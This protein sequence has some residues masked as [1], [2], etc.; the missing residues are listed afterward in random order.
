MLIAATNSWAVSFDNLSTIQPWLSDSLCRL[1]TGGGLSVREL[2]SDD[3]ER[4]FDCVRP[5][6]IAAIENVAV[7]GDL[8]DRCLVVAL[9][10]I[11]KGKRQDER[12]FW[13]AFEEARPAILGALLDAIAVG[14]GRIDD[15]RTIDTRMAD[16]ATWVTACELKCPW[17]PGEFVRAYA[18]MRRAAIDVTLESNVLGGPIQKLIGDIGG[19]E[20]TAAC[21][22]ETI[23]ADAYSDD[24]TRRRRDWPTTPRGLSGKLRRIAPELRSVGVNIIFDE[25]KGKSRS[26]TIRIEKT[27]T[28]PSAPYLPSANVDSSL[29]TAIRADGTNAK[30]DGTVSPYRPPENRDSGIENAGADG[31]DGRD[32]SYGPVSSDHRTEQDMDIAD[33]WGVV[34]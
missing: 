29:G 3:E 6:V 32:G 17:E 30:A 22:L 28:V 20:G 16:Y 19:W 34:A 9:P 13:P 31:R 15:I 26:R 18:N 2:Y 1:S 23:C 4:I 5:V 24:K 27:G 11:E 10:Q 33:G 12:T 21:L 14:L 8:L 25:R 7:Q